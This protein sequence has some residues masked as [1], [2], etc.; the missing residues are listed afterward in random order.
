M[1][2]RA[3][4]V[5]YYYQ[6]ITK[7]PQAALLY[8]CG[9]QRTL[10]GEEQNRI[11]RHGDTDTDRAGGS[12]LLLG[13]DEPRS[14]ERRQPVSEAGPRTS[15]EAVIWLWRI[16]PYAVRDE[17]ELSTFQDAHHHSLVQQAGLQELRC[18]RLERF[19]HE[20]LAPYENKASQEM[21]MSLLR[22]GD[23]RPFQEAR[24]GI[25]AAI[26]RLFAG[27]QTVSVHGP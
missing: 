17:D 7:S 25:R 1:S 22:A 27:L 24:Q 23:H 9:W 10:A 2:A 19:S 21:G 20:L 12:A 14:R 26:I 18:L 11:S 6:P 13:P 15:S 16:R 3:A 4:S 8:E 5:L